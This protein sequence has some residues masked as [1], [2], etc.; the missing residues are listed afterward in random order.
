MNDADFGGITVW[1]QLTG[2][3]QNSFRFPGLFDTLPG[4]L[5][6]E[7]KRSSRKEKGCPVIPPMPIIVGSPRS[8]TTLLRLM[9]DAHPELAIPPETGFLTF[10]FEEAPDPEVSRSG[11]FSAITSYPLESPGW[12]D[13]QIS[14]EDFERKLR[15]LQPFSIAQGLRLFYRMYASRFQKLRWGDKTPL[16][17]RHLR[18]IEGLLPE[19]RFIHLIRDGRDAAVSLRKQWFSPG[20]EIGIQAHYWRDNVTTAREQG[21]SC[22]HYM[23]VR[24]E[25]V[26]RDSPTVLRAICGFLDL[27]YHPDMLR[28]HERA[29]RRLEEHTGRARAD[30]STVV[31]REARLRQQ[32]LTKQPPDVSRIGAWRSELGEEDRRE[33]QAIAGDL[34]QE[35][36]YPSW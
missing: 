25:E 33:F 34:L 14:A 17:C 9:L 2:Q 4:T 22:R 3:P 7:P 11:F 20:Y 8:G 36:G 28:Y 30:G 16:Y 1:L 26:V 12:A 32:E 15:E 21:S 29:S 24:Y 18:Q 31:T 27:D 35:L 23:E 5:E 10:P 19:A 6:H 13:F